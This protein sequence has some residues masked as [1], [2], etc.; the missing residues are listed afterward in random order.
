MISPMAPHF[1]SELWSRLMLAPRFT[2][3]KYS[4]INWSKHVL[5][6]SWPEVDL[7][8]ELSVNVKINC[9]DVV[10][11]KYPR[12]ILDNLKYES[13]FDRVMNDKSVLELISDISLQATRFE[14]YPGC[15]GVFHIFLNQPIKVKKDK[16]SKKKAVQ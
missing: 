5:T 12:K 7:E 14:L 15:H 13:V 3:N 1:A 11:Y 8:H 16:K 6:Q 10:S 9:V 2:S 4:E